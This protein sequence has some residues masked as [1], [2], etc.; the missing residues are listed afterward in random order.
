MNPNPGVFALL[1][2]DSSVVALLKNGTQPLRVFP[3]GEAPQN[4]ATPYV[5][6]A[7]VNGQPA[8]LIDQKPLE[9]TM[10]VQIDV[11]GRTVEE[12]SELMDVVSAVLEDNG[13]M[14]SFDTAERDPGT[15]LYRGRMD[16]DIIKVR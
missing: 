15:K 12:A 16:F 9:D 4:V 3:W 2:D 6:Y 7:V 8:N 13:H 10:I 5:T 14:T 11:W 1:A